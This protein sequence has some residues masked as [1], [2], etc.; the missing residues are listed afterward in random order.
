MSKLSEAEVSGAL[1][2]LPGWEGDTTAIR[3][4]FRFGDFAGAMAFVNRVADVAEELDH[5]PDIA[6]SWSRVDLTISSHAAGGVTD[7]CVE[8]ARRIDPLGVDAGA[9]ASASE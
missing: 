2:A 7:G 8:L 1:E 3:R 4:T 9:G 6:I 5:H